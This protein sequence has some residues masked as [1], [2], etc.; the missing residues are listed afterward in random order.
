MICCE[1][2]INITF[3]LYMGRRQFSYKTN[4]I[5]KI[6]YKNIVNVTLFLFRQND[7]MFR[8]YTLSSLTICVTHTYL[9]LKHDIPYLLI[10]YNHIKLC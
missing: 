9:G 8:V 5:P 4:L 3:L 7:I 2:I 10:K 6:C 1:N